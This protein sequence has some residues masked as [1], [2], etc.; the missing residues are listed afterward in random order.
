MQIFYIF[1]TYSVILSLAHGLTKT[2]AIELKCGL[3]IGRVLS[4]KLG[5]GFW[6]DAFPWLALDVYR[7]FVELFA[8]FYKN[9][10]LYLISQSKNL[11]IRFSQTN[12]A[13]ELIIKKGQEVFTAC[14]WTWTQKPLPA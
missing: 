1:D 11:E 6:Y 4:K 12:I 9:L 8:Q 13:L 2:Y 14:P 10:K 3:H 7:V 5:C